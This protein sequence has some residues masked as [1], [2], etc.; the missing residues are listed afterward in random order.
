[1]KRN[2]KLF[3]AVERTV[4]RRQ[5][6]RHLEKEVR[7]IF[8]AVDCNWRKKCIE[9]VCEGVLPAVDAEIARR[10]A[11][12]PVRE[13]RLKGI[14]WRVMCE[15]F[16]SSGRTHRPPF[17]EENSYQRAWFEHLRQSL[18]ALFLTQLG[19]A[20]S[21]SAAVLLGGIVFGGLADRK[22]HR[23]L[24]ESIADYPIA[25]FEHVCIELRH[26][27]ETVDDQNKDK[28]ARTWVRKPW[29]P[30][31][32]VAALLQPMI[33][34]LQRINKPSALPEFERVLNLAL[35]WVRYASKAHGFDRLARR[36][37]RMLYAYLLEGARIDLHGRMPST[38][39]E[40]CAGNVQ[41]TSLPAEVWARCDRAKA[42]ITVDTTDAYQPLQILLRTA[43]GNRDSISTGRGGR[44]TDTAD[45]EEAR[46]L[47]QR[48]HLGQL[49]KCIG[50]F[51][52]KIKDSSKKKAEGYLG[53]RR[54]RLARALVEFHAHHD[55]GNDLVAALTG[56]AHWLA[57]QRNRHGNTVTPKTIQRYIS[58][59]GRALIAFL[60]DT[61][62]LNCTESTFLDLYG[63]AL[64]AESDDN[65]SIDLAYE[66]SDFHNFLAIELD[67]DPVDLRQTGVPLRGRVE[68]VRANVVFPA[69]LQAAQ[70][71]IANH[72]GLA[73]RERLAAQSLLTLITGGGSRV[74]EALGGWL[75][76]LVLD[77][78][79]ECLYVFDHRGRSTKS[80]NAN[81]PIPLLLTED[82]RRTL[83][84]FKK[85]RLGDPHHDPKDYLFSTGMAHKDPD[86]AKTTY[87]IVREALYAATGDPGVTPHTLRH[88]YFTY[89]T[90][91]L[92]QNKAARADRWGFSEWA[93]GTDATELPYQVAR[94]GRSA[95]SIEDLKDLAREGGHG[96]SETSIRH[97]VHCFD[98]LSFDYLDMN[99][100]P[101]SDREIG[102]LLAINESDV[103]KYR[104]RQ[105]D[106]R[107]EYR[108]VVAWVRRGRK[109]QPCGPSRKPISAPAHMQ[110]TRD[111]AFSTITRVLKSSA[112]RSVAEV[113]RQVGLTKT[114]VEDL[115][116]V[117]N[118][119]ARQTRYDRHQPGRNG[120]GYVH[121]PPRNLVLRD[122]C[123][124]FER[125]ARESDAQSEIRALATLWRKR[126][127]PKHSALYVA[128]VDEAV[129]LS[130]YL[131]TL[132]FEDRLALVETSSMQKTLS[133]TERQE[134]LESWKQATGISIVCTVA[135]TSSGVTVQN[136]PDGPA[137]ALP[138]VT[139]I[140]VDGAG[141]EVQNFQ[142]LHYMLFLANVLFGWQ[143][144]QS[145]K[146]QSKPRRI[147]P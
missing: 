51:E 17:T 80:N 30:P 119:I 1:M 136:E 56:Y 89:L 2:R 16:E 141:R 87:D 135:P 67:A 90:L 133:K 8:D 63:R 144:E 129:A 116:A 98:S 111:V 43:M 121:R 72:P 3:G 123:M 69:E 25:D 19:D 50:K 33:Q 5:K 112:A 28:G 77:K 94:S 6:T 62:F 44:A 132:V 21:A 120:A 31:A 79:A 105:G 35:D 115:V 61:A 11:Q 101:L 100:P 140:S 126:Y 110:R 83:T 53:E 24:V 95:P 122:S 45:R 109:R 7:S 54:S 58:S 59:L 57:K 145:S 65:A 114:E 103:A 91:W 29:E 107:G 42:P 47:Q 26:E 60:P 85:L 104:G 106:G 147:S 142:S 146:P 49:I 78:G 68:C 76:H 32:L 34:Q 75:E 88:T 139:V 55:L 71:W 82:G 38:L 13:G 117:A 73:H 131:R 12:A 84:E 99:N 20:V 130:R 22:Y 48:V 74:G 118:E 14:A 18:P 41:S 66:L 138:G 134:L 39:A 143:E 9:E 127:R 10:H 64:A 128:S 86:L 137:R 124:R 102:S 15:A 93:A 113:A 40:Y 52:S 96:R 108:G 81:R 27:E 46:I 4:M 37:D 70:D 92:M 36:S 23:H 125:R 97:Y